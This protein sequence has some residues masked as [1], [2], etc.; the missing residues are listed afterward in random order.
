MNSFK[1]L[2]IAGL[3]IGSISANAAPITLPGTAVFD[4]NADPYTFTLDWTGGPNITNPN[5]WV[6]NINY[7]VEND[8]YYGYRDGGGWGDGVIDWGLRAIFNGEGDALNPSKERILGPLLG[9]TYAYTVDFSYYFSFDDCGDGVGCYE[10]G[11]SVYE[12]TM[13]SFFD[14]AAAVP[15]GPTAPLLAAGLAGLLLR[16]K[17]A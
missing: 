12:T 14:S 7:T 3:L 2:L 11:G 5:V 13:I 16:R 10:Y 1:V 17:R 15:V 6:P 4:I 8:I 9:E